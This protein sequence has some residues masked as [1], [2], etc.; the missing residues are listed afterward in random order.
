MSIKK[1]AYR[2]A[3]ERIRAVFNTLPPDM[4]CGELVEDEYAVSYVDGAEYDG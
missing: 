2:E 4:S 1:K 3:W